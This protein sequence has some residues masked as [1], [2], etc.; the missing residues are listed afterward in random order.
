MGAQ[1]RE[2][3]VGTFLLISKKANVDC[4]TISPFSVK[5]SFSPSGKTTAGDEF[6]KKG[7]RL[8]NQ[9][10]KVGHQI[11]S[12]VG[13]LLGKTFKCGEVKSR[14]LTSPHLKVF[15]KCSLGVSMASEFCSRCSR[16]PMPRV[17]TGLG[18]VDRRG[19]V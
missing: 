10:V 16:I 13:L 9:G 11:G 12:T 1:F 5:V 4:Q 14:D 3:H 15:P 7:R 6:R 18:V 2:V 8:K 17:A 19:R